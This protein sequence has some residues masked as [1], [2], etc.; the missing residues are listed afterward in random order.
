MYFGLD[1]LKTQVELLLSVYEGRYPHGLDF[2]PLHTQL[3]NDRVCLNWRR[4]KL[5]L[6]LTRNGLTALTE[7]LRLLNRSPPVDSALT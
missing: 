7:G 2:R 4:G 1:E 6:R 3:H 5:T